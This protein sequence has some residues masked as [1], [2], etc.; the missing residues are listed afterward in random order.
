[1]QVY[2]SQSE[3]ETLGIGKEIGKQLHSPLAVLLYGELGAGKTVLTRGLAEG[4]GVPDP[5]SVRSPSFTLVN[6]YPCPSGVLYHVD[7]YR[8]EGPR[9]LYSVGIEEILATP[10]VLIVEWAEKLLIEPERAMRI[11]ITVGSSQNERSLEVDPAA[12][13]TYIRVNPLR[14]A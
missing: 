14:S 1:M 9:D 13:K 12:Q 8:L 10:S 2:Y 5:S 6:E 4:L 3:Q 11:R 7:L